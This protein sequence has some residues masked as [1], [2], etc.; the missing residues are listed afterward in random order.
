MQA[1]AALTGKN[2]QELHQIIEKSN[3]EAE[4]AHNLI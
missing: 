2:N 1:L 4:L 3:T